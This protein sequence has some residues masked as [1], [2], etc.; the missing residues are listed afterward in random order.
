[1]AWP[2]DYPA[3]AYRYYL[4]WRIAPRGLYNARLYAIVLFDLA[5]GHVDAESILDCAGV[6]VPAI[7]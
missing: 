3:L 4:S 2:A 1:M 5:I 7:R 6:A